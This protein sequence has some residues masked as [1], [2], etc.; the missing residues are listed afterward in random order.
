MNSGSVLP[1]PMHHRISLE[2][3]PHFLKSGKLKLA[4]AVAWP[5]PKLTSVC[6][7]SLVSE[8]KSSCPSA[9]SAEAFQALGGP[10]WR[11][12]PLP[13]K[14]MVTLRRVEMTLSPSGDIAGRVDSPA[15][16]GSERKCEPS[17]FTA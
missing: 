14:R 17:T 11:A 6:P 9:P 3:N 8:A 2:L 13:N 4:F 12:K 1:P 7:A 15:A 16:A 5:G 10:Y